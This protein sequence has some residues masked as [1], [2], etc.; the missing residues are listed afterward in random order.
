MGR[1]EESNSTNVWIHRTQ[2]DTIG[3]C[4]IRTFAIG[5]SSSR[6][7]EIF[8][9][10]RNIRVETLLQSQIES[11]TKQITLTTKDINHY[12]HLHDATPFRCSAVRD[13]W[14]K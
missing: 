1:E 11:I 13:C 8:D 3:A 9:G 2:S 7:M 6:R 4:F 5:Y 12:F 10:G 14:E